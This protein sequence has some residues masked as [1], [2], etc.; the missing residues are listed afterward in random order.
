LDSNLSIS[1]G[2]VPLSSLPTTQQWGGVE[3]LL[4]DTLETVLPALVIAILMVIFVVQPTLVEGRSM[5]PTLYPGQRLVIEKISY[6]F[7][8]PQRGDIVVLKLPQRE[9]TPLIKRVIATAGDIV[10]IREG[11]VY[12]NGAALDEPYLTT[13]SADTY[14][15]A[16]VPEGYLFVLGDNRGASKDSRAFGMVSVEQLVGR[17]TVRYWPLNTVGMIP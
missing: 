13:L 4:R 9:A 15:S 16:M 8:A 1:E 2:S 14:P 3:S 12:V 17:A 7:Q 10:A 11:I 6:H 5:A